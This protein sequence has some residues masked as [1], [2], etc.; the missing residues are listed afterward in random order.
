MNDVKLR[1]RRK[2]G[3]CWQDN[4]LYDAFGP[5]I[6]PNAVLVYVQ[7]TREC[8]GGETLVSA[9][10]R[11]LAE[12]CG[13]SRDTVWRALKVMERV[14]MTRLAGGGDRRAGEYQLVDLK[15]LA[16]A[17]GAH[18]DVERR[19]YLLSAA[20]AVSLRLAVKEVLTKVQRK[21]PELPIDISRSVK[22][23]PPVEMPLPVS[24]SVAQSDSLQAASVAQGDSSPVAGATDL[25]RGS[26]RSV[27]PAGQITSNCK[28]EDKDNPPTPR[29][30]GGTCS[31][32]WDGRCTMNCGPATPPAQQAESIE[33][34]IAELR[35]QRAALPQGSAAWWKVSREL[36]A[37]LAVIAPP[38]PGVQTGA[39][40]PLTPGRRRRRHA[41]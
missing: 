20:T 32:C 8:W 1:D 28:K 7:M 39:D 17:L 37:L 23:A 38:E 15:E 29:T 26:D 34:K 25:V 18:F 33:G 36:Q 3:H 41:M 22:I 19:S 13:L 30:A 9:S 5:I 40:P 16:I 27:A 4:E 10:S 2:P 6:G 21:S 24:S 14:G 12:A 31:D 11:E 35:M